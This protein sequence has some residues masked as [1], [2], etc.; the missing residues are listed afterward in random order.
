MRTNPV[1][2]GLHIGDPTAEIIKAD[3]LA[4]VGLLGTAFTMEQDFYKGRLAAEHGLDVM[5]PDAADRALGLA[6]NAS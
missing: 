2:V 3:G 4:R 6:G 5:V 1:R